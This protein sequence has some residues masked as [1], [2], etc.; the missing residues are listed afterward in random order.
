[1]GTCQ[2][3]R[4]QFLPMVEAAL[5]DDNDAVRYVAAASVPRLTSVSQLNKSNKGCL[6]LVAAG[7][8]PVSAFLV[9]QANLPY[10]AITNS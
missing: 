3:W 8:R 9:R 5:S 7:R 1:M 2:A 6:H 4:S 10:S